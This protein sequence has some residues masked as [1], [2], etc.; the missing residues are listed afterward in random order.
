M[1]KCEQSVPKAAMQQI[2]KNRNRIRNQ[3]REEE[4]EE[5]IYV[6]RGDLEDVNEKNDEAEVIK[7]GITELMGRK[8][9]ELKLLSLRQKRIDINEKTKFFDKLGGDIQ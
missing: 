9:L 3:R 1:D 8:I 5:S 4:E 6:N 2:I 7:K